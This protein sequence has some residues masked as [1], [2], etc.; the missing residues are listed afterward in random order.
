MHSYTLE[1]ARKIVLKCAKYYEQNLLDKNY[2]MIY[3]DIADN[4]IKN[5][6]V[7]FG[8]ENY[9]HLAGIELI[10]KNAV[11]RQHVSV[12]FYN[13]CINN[14]L[15]KDE[16]KFKNDGTTNFKLAAL[17]FLMTIQKITKIAGDYNNARPYLAADK[18]VG[19]VNFCLGLKQT[20]N[21][22]VPV[23]ALLE[24][25]SK[26]TKTQSQVLAIFSKKICDEVYMDIR[27]VAKGVNL[28]N[29]KLPQDTI[30]KISLDNYVPKDGSK[31]AYKQTGGIK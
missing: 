30:N 23:S 16:I 25:I 9:Q 5:L 24:D 26:L 7:Q 17:P 27:H 20:G 12:L 1:E 6:E 19:N 18:L 22:Y 3:K 31:S 28:H 2:I 8:R 11:V 4:T 13:K 14:T 10:D 15:A 29:I 21:Y